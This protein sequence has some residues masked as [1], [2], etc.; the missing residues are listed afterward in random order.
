M[1]DQTTATYCGAWNE[2]LSWLI[3]NRPFAH[4]GM[5]VSN[6]CDREEYRTVQINMAKKYGIP[7]IDM[8]GDRFTPVM[9]RSQNPDIS[10]EVKKTVMLKQAVDYPH[11]TH[12]ND[13]AHEY[14]SCFIED[15]L[16]R[17]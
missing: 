7:Y 15:F 10:A 16:R 12:P 4:I 2:V 8:N 1:D 11:N 17:I 3:E 9:I 14:E 5:L 13:K 6:G